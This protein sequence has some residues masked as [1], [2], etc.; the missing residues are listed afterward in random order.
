M[1]AKKVNGV[2]DQ[3]PERAS[4][5]VGNSYALFRTEKET[6]AE[7]LPQTAEP[8]PAKEVLTP[9]VD[10]ETVSEPVEVAEPE[11]TALP[12]NEPVE[13][14]EAPALEEREVSEE[15]PAKGPEVFVPQAPDMEELWQSVTA[16]V[17]DL[18]A[19]EETEQ[20]T[21]PAEEPEELSAEDATQPPESEPEAAADE[22][23]AA[24][25]WEEVAADG[26]TQMVE[27][28]LPQEKVTAADEPQEEPSA[29]LADEAPQ[30]S[31]K[32]AMRHGRT[33]GQ[34]YLRKNA[35]QLVIGL[36]VAL[37]V[38]ALVG[39]LAKLSVVLFV[40]LAGVTYLLTC[41]FEYRQYRRKLLRH[42]RST[43][44]QP[45]TTEEATEQESE[46]VWDIHQ[47]TLSTKDFDTNVP[48]DEAAEEP[49]ANVKEPE[50]E[51]SS[52]G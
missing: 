44:R 48:Q 19:S 24:S 37:G 36:V 25:E 13:D 43:Y 35:Q 23:A 51:L 21:M 27:Q 49:S 14:P 18:E 8:E 15:A 10:T 22:D 41:L 11:E 16:Q 7:D 42:L 9:P 52:N 28:P 12:I 32:Y 5:L 4:S 29:Q 31:G 38:G 45:V 34:E 17:D 1:S 2:A 30:K 6:P 50:E 3:E 39:V 46:V 33:M 20:E 26:T 40:L 47:E